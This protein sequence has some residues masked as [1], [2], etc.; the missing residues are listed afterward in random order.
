MGIK[1]RQDEIV[2]VI[3]E[4]GE[5]DEKKY[6]E[7]NGLK[8]WD[9]TISV[10]RFLFW[11][12]K[13]ILQGEEIELCEEKCERLKI[14]LEGL[15]KEED[16]NYISV[17]KS[18]CDLFNKINLKAVRKIFNLL[19][20]YAKKYSEKMRIVICLNENRKKLSVERRKIELNNIEAELKKLFSKKIKDKEKTEQ[21]INRIFDGYKRQYKKFFRFYK[22]REGATANYKLD[23]SVIL[24][25]EKRDGIF[26]LTT[27]H[28]QEALPAKKV[29][30]SY[31][32]LREV[33]ELFDD[34]KNFVDI[35]PIRHWLVRRVRSHV[36]LCVLALLLKRIFEIDCL[37]SKATTIPL[38]E[39]AK[40]K[41][42]INKIKFSHKSDAYQIVPVV[43]N[44]SDFQKHIFKV[45]GVKNPMSI[46]KFTW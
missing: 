7:W 19:K 10:K 14:E 8:I 9:K 35:H 2:Q 45:A 46:D 24:S 21:N 41:L 17:K 44:L 25:E 16:F 23:E 11:K 18:I 22:D 31:K 36:F 15:I 33:E 42:V 13:N 37:K 4:D 32:N 6:V 20:K 30:E 34:L 26:I 5:L 38:E 12:I 3:F 40:V 28:G 29:V 43:T 39:I 1:H 27:N